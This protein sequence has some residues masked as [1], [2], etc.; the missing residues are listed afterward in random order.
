MSTANQEWNIMAT[1]TGVYKIVNRNSSQALEIGG[2][3]WNMEQPGSVAHQWTDWGGKNQQWLFQPVYGSNVYFTITNANS[4]QVL[5]IGGGAPI[6][7]QP[8][9]I[10]NQWPYAGKDFY[11]QQWELVPVNMQTSTRFPGVYTIKNVNSQKLLEIGG[12][13]TDPGATVN[14]WSDAETANQQWTL[15]ETSSGIFKIVNRNSGLVLRIGLS[16]NVANQ[17]W[18]TGALNEQWYVNEIT[19]GIFK[20]TNLSSSSQL[21][22][23]QGAYKFDGATVDVWP[24][25]GGTNQQ[26]I[27]TQISQNRVAGQTGNDKNQQSELS[28]NM[29]TGAD[30]QVEVAPKLSLFPNPASTVLNLSLSGKTKFALVKVSDIRGAVI[31]TMRYPSSNQLDIS[32]LSAGVYLLMVSDGKRDYHQKFIKQ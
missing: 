5:E 16:G 32:S 28:K 23:I 7:V 31:L 15:V 29:V 14:Q 26:W 1:G 20:I 4:G 11:E 2:S 6:N 19:P 12:A 8:G 24:Y 27:L 30:H 9:A 17:G 10:A 21:L 25:G 3:S 13:S 18:Y 22:E